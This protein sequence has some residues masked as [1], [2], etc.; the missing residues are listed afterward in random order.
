MIV[1]STKKNIEHAQ[2]RRDEIID[3]CLELYENFNF[4]DISIKDIAEY[5]SFSRPSIYNYFETKEEIFLA[6][7]QREYELWEEDLNKIAKGKKVL[8]VKLFAKQL[9]NTLENRILLLRLLSMNL[10]DMEE[11]SSMER[12]IEFK[13]AYGSSI[14]ALTKALNR[15]F[16]KYTKTNCEKFIYSFLAFMVG[17]YPNTY[18]TKK[19]NKAMEKAGI[20]FK[21]Y[22]I[23][24][25]AYN[26]IIKLLED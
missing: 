20:S 11:H 7:F 13:E 17:I 19:Q 12:L 21:K 14:K 23:Y 9:A 18:F 16:P 2:A 3:A 24:E 4:K 22:S 25:L 5:T 6:I 15:A 1:K 8:T 26:T 10:F